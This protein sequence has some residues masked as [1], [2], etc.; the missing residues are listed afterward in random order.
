MGKWDDDIALVPRGTVEPTTVAALLHRL[1]LTGA[2]EPVRGVAISAW[3]RAH[4][5]SPLLAHSLRRKGYG[6]LPE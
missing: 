5:P 1:G 2:A 4:S 3:L 6:R